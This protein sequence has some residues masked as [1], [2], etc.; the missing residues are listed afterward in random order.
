MIKYE[1]ASFDK[2]ELL[3]FTVIFFLLL[4]IAASLSAQNNSGIAARHPNVIFILAD[5]MGYGDLGCYGQQKIS[6]PHIDAMAKSGMRFTQ[7]YAGTS[8]CAPSRASLM[9]GLHTG[10]TPIRGNLEVKPEGQWPIPD[11]TYTMAEMFKQ[12]GYVT[13]DFGKW[14]LGYVGSTGDPVKQ[15]FDRFYGYNCQAQAHNYFPDHLWDNEQKIELQNTLEKQPQYAAD[16]IQNQALHFIDANSSKPF[17]LFLSYTLPHAGLQLPEGD[18]CFERYK[19]Q[20]NETPR[21]VSSGWNGKSYQPQ[22]YPRAAYAAMVSRLDRYVG[23]VMAKLKELKLDRQTLVI[24]TSD[25][26]PHAE[27]GNDYAFFNSNG[28]FRGIKRDLYEGGIRE[29][30]IASWPGV[31]KAGSLSRQT[32]AFWDFFPTFAA[33]AGQQIP[34]T[35]DGLSILPALTGKGIQKQHDYLYW[36]FHENGGRQAVLLGKWKGIRLNV[37]KEPGGDIELYDLSTDPGEKIN[38]AAS[39]PS[40]VQQIKKI[41]QEAHVENKDFPLFK[42]T[43]LRIE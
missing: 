27:G 42:P 26:G 16:M 6:T 18:T 31:I 2:K 35:V 41:M 14:G 5:D 22:P 4:S 19:K 15:G 33:I 13:G 10:H 34:S 38:L 1:R 11:S 25:N 29:P 24:F 23:Q 21:P 36:E 12:A 37:T 43:A 20:F 8:V 7:F 28:G 9:T 39:N 32:G 40:V 30:M 17:F 3:R